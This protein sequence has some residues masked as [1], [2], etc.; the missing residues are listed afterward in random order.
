MQK[1]AVLPLRKTTK[2]RYRGQKPIRIA[3]KNAGIAT[4]IF[5]GGYKR[6][7]DPGQLRDRFAADLSLKSDSDISSA[8]LRNQTQNPREAP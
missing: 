1:A 6:T 4:G 5:E 8:R 7:P 2:I 3:L